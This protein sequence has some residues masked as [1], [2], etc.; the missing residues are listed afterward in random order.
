M[1]H[2]P[3]EKRWREVGLCSLVTRRLQGNIEA[4][5]QLTSRLLSRRGQAP[6][7]RARL[8]GE[9]VEIEEV[10]TRYKEKFL[11]HDES[12]ALR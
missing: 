4:A 8:G 2:L 6:H 9:A 3:Y 1:E 11:Y 12:Q 7:G 5:G 10:E